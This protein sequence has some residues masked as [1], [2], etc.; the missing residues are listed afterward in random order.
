MCDS[1]GILQLPPASTARVHMHVGSI[2]SLSRLAAMPVGFVRRCRGSV[3]AEPRG[4]AEGARGGEGVGGG[5]WQVA[6]AEWLLEQA[7]ERRNSDGMSHC[8]LGVIYETRHDMDRVRPAPARPPAD[9]A[10]WRDGVSG[11]RGARARSFTRCCMCIL[12]VGD[13]CELR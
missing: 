9:L 2:A 12:C 4:G 5:W 11:P 8:N 6:E 1:D 13:T 10:G 3:S 7:V